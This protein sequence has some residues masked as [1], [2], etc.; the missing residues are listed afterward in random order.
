LEGYLV[1]VLLMSFIQ[2]ILLIYLGCMVVFCIALWVAVA[3]R[4]KMNS[5]PVDIGVSLYSERHNQ[6]AKLKDYVFNF[7]VIKTT[8][9]VEEN[10]ERRLKRELIEK[11]Q[12]E[13]HTA[14][15]ITDDMNENKVNQSI[16]NEE[17]KDNPYIIKKR[18]KTPKTKS[19]MSPTAYARVKLK[20]KLQRFKHDSKIH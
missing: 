14:L 16:I 1:E 2:T 19:K 5:E 18:V 8:D 13:V 4:S 12:E 11:E 17:P 6:E 9:V 7:P 3:F 15:H 10:K 20:E